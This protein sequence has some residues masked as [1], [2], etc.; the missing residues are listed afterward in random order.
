MDMPSTLKPFNDSNFQQFQQL[1]ALQQQAVA[2]NHQNNDLLQKIL[3]DNLAKQQSN[4]I[5]NKNKQ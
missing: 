3:N 4:F 1:Y 2:A 5:D